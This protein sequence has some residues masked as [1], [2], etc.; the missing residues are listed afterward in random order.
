[1]SKWKLPT[2]SDSL[3]QAT[4]N[5]DGDGNL[6]IEL[7][8][9]PKQQDEYPLLPRFGV[10]LAVPK[11]VDQVAWYGR[12][13][14]ETYWDRKTGGEIALYESTA[15]AMPYDY[16]RTQD[17]GNRT[18]TRWFSVEDKSGRGLKFEAAGEPV[19]FSVLPYSLEDL[20]KASHAYE[21]PR[22]GYN[23]V[24]IDSKVH[25]VGGDNSWGARTHRE[26]TLPGNEPHRLRF[27]IK[28]QRAEK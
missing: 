10:M 25:G 24:F 22:T 5:I 16:A 19:S 9:D 8:L 1:V 27:V 4:Y 18:D 26:Y 2:A 14:H 17:T 21:L 12:G 15:E 7:K 3:L 20:M 11:E 13:P 6:A 28:P 23:M